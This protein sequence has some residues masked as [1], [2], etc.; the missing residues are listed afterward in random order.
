MLDCGKFIIY[1]GFPVTTRLAWKMWDIMVTP[2]FHFDN[3]TTQVTKA[4]TGFRI[5][6]NTFRF[7][8]ELGFHRPVCLKKSPKFW[9]FLFESVLKLEL[10]NIKSQF[11]VK[12]FVFSWY[13]IKGSTLLSLDNQ[14]KPHLCASFH[15]KFWRKYK[16]FHSSHKTW[17]KKW[18]ISLHQFF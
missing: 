7:F 13:D 10:L 9:S 11:S 5:F 17:R 12:L 16:K 1:E 6:K 4:F 3:L 15:A 8:W 2:P 14:C 18:I